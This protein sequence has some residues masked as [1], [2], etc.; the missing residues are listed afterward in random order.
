MIKP[1]DQQIDIIIDDWTP[2]SKTPTTLVK[3]ISS[4]VVVGHPTIICNFKP[5]WWWMK[6]KTTKGVQ[7]HHRDHSNI[8]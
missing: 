8:T 6:C 3:P 1:I 2:I 4:V 5:R 7:L